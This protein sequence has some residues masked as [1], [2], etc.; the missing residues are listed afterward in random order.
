MIY[1][2]MVKKYGYADV[3]ADSEEEAKKRT[4]NMWDAEFDWAE[5]TAD[6]AEVV[7]DWE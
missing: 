7:E 6:D 3:E 4:E 1:H 2:M 5:R